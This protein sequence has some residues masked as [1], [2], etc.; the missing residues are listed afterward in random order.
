M[1]MFERMRVESENMLKQ[2]DHVFLKLEALKWRKLTKIKID[3][4]DKKKLLSIKI[5]FPVNQNWRQ[6]QASAEKG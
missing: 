2:R 3:Y 1:T 6:L 4:W 5:Q